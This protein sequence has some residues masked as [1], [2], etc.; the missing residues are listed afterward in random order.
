MNFG[1]SDISSRLLGTAE[2]KYIYIYIS[3]INIFLILNY[4][5]VTL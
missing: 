5:Y 1:T 4:F 2:N 3:R